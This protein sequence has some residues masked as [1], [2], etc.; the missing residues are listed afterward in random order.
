MSK[1]TKKELEAEILTIK[2][3]HKSELKKCLDVIMLKDNRLLTQGSEIL[4]LSNA[5]ASLA[6][7]L[8]IS[9]NAHEQL[10]WQ[11]DN[12]DTGIN[13]ALQVMDI[14]VGILYPTLDISAPLNADDGTNIT[15]LKHIREALV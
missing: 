2:K 13:D 8:S 11:I 4:R 14:G 9:R 3:D 10:S 7:E 15:L 1:R 6:Q 12:L 5:N